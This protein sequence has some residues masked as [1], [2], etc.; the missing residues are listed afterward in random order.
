MQVL[1]SIAQLARVPGPTVLA[2]GVFDGVHLGH[3]AVLNRALADAAQRGGNSVAVTFDPHPLRVLRPDKAPRLLTS[4]AHKIRLIQNLGIPY[5]LIIPFDGGFAATSPE[6]FIVALARAAPLLREICVGHQWSFGKGRA[7]NLESLR[8]LGDRLGFDEVG[9]EA[10]KVDG[11]VVSSTLVRNA[12]E[13]GDLL[14]VER[15]LGRKFTILGTVVMGDRRART[16]GFPT[17]N[18]AAHNEQF[19]P[20]GV[21]AARTTRGLKSHGGVV[22]IGVRPTF[23]QEAGERVL[24]LH[25]LDFSGDIYGE[26][27]E[28]TF[29]KFLR[30]ERKFANVDDLRAQIANDIVKVRTALSTSR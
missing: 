6:D 12:V 21:Y 8:A 9:V 24:E 26:E 10:V 2:I 25:L 17:A 27:V 14:R 20:N 22:N 30:P 16:L 4:T 5:L 7:G 28:V 18:L 15:F 3:Q 29:E 13:S 23:Y 1:H 19:P 11:D